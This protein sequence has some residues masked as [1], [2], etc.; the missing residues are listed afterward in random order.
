MKNFRTR[1]QLALALLCGHA[2][3]Y[4][5]DIRY[6]EID[7]SRHRRIHTAESIIESN[8][9][10]TNAPVIIYGTGHSSGN[11]GD[12]LEDRCTG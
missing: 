6:G 8:T 9:I 3:I 10:I 1:V 11:T 12:I 5:A 7:I 2:V 4:G